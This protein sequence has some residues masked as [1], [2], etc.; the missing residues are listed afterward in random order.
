MESLAARFDNEVF[1]PYLE[2][3]QAEYRIHPSFEHAQRIWNQSL[4]AQELVNGPYLERSQIYE[5]GD[6]LDSLG[7]HPATVATL[8][9]RLGGRPL[10]KHQADALKLLLSRKN[11]VIATGTS[12]G[13]TLWYQIPI[14]D[15]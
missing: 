13:K 9:S 4:T 3:L 6:A 8:R 10:Y 1:R 12:S 14:L 11:A 2:L 7:L 5:P 15:E